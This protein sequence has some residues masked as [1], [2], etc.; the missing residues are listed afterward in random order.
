[1]LVSECSRQYF[2]LFFSTSATPTL[3]RRGK[4]E[5]NAHTAARFHQEEEIAL[6]VTAPLQFSVVR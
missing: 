5:N 2:H 4:V 6:P 1:M 3:E